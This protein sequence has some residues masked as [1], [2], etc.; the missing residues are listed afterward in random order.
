MDLK[1]YYINTM[2]I[3]PFYPIRWHEEMEIVKVQCGKGMFRV[4]GKEYVLGQGDIVIL[5]PFVMYSINRLGDNEINMDAIMFNLRL[6]ETDETDAHTLKYFAPLLNEKHS[7]PCVVRPNENWY[8]SFNKCVSSI[9]SCDST[10]DDAED[11]IKSNLRTMFYHIYNNR[12]TNVQHSVTEDKQLYTVRRA[13]EYI[14]SEY[15]KE[16]TVKNIASHC[17]YSEFYMM[18]LF[19]QFTGESVVDYVNKYRL[20]VAG[21]QLRTTIDDISAIAYQVGYNNI[22][23]F[24]RQ[25]KHL[26]GTTPRE[27]RLNNN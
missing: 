9:L 2:D 20:T 15:T 3:S 11:N 6:I 10:L 18:K 5:R 4:D 25:F 27:F 1:C 13:L 26:Y 19:K 8:S 16:I 17:G 12:L 14:R 23:Y 22:S 7:V 21:Q 24:N